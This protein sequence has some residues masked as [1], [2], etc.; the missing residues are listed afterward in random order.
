MKKFVWLITFGTALLLGVVTLNAQAVTTLQ[1]TSSGQMGHAWG[2]MNNDGYLDLYICHGGEPGDLFINNGN[3]TLTLKTK[4]TVLDSTNNASYSYGALWADFD[5]DGIPDLLFT[6]GTTAPAFKIYRSDGHGSF[7]SDLTSTLF[8][9]GQPAYT[10]PDH[11]ATILPGVADYDRSGHLS[12][13]IGGTYT[14][15]DDIKLYHYNTTTGK[16]DNLDIATVLPGNHKVTSYNPAWV[17]IDNDGWVDLFL[18]DYNGDGALLYKNNKNGTFT[19]VTATNFPSVPISIASAWADFNNDG[20]MDLIATGNDG[21]IKLFQN[22]KNGT[23]TDVTEASGVAAAFAAVGGVRGISCGDIDN[24]GYVDVIFT[25]SVSPIGNFGNNL[26][27]LHNNGKMTFTDITASYVSSLTS[28]NISNEFRSNTMVDVNN[29]G[30]VDIILEAYSNPQ[31]YVLFDSTNSNKWIAFKPIGSGLN[32]SAIGTRFKVYAKLSGVSADPDT[33]QIRDI[34][35]G[36]SG[37]MTGGNLWANF[38]LRNASSVDSVVVLWA[39]GSKQTYTGLATNRY[40]T[41]KQGA[42]PVAGK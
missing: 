23:F 20:Y 41:V 10:G 15:Q 29:D 28:A 36:G 11:C 26:V 18:P 25:G 42:A 7:S 31:T 9:A 40:W 2:D 34:Q 14:T 21:S 38:G 30:F 32:T 37:S 16:Y 33:V 12:L 35:G 13:V 24:D 3:N 6:N 1:Y 5:G 17:D 8:A 39:D 27:V 22:N 4:N 19:N